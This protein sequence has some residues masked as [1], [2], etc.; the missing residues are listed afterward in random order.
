LVP[1]DK[2]IQA[3]LQLTVLVLVVSINM[4]VVVADL[5]EQEH[6]QF[7]L[8]LQVFLVEQQLYGHIPVFIMPVVVVVA[9]DFWQ[10]Q[11][12]MVVV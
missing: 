6:Q 9:Q 5:A 8:P 4:A 1:E 10:H 11:L 2:V 7:Q 3:A 12:G